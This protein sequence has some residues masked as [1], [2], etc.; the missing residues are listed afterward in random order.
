[1]MRQTHKRRRV[2][3]SFATKDALPLLSPVVGDRICYE[4]WAGD[5]LHEEQALRRMQE[6]GSVY[7][8]TWEEKRHERTGDGR[9]DRGAGGYRLHL[10]DGLGLHEGGRLP[11]ARTG[12]RVRIPAP[13][14]VPAMVP[15]RNGGTD[16]AEPSGR[17]AV[18]RRDRVED[19]ASRD[20]GR[21]RGGLDQ[22]PSRS[23]RSVHL[24]RGAGRGSEATVCALLLIVALLVSVTAIQCDALRR[25]RRRADDVLGC[26][27]DHGAGMAHPGDRDRLEG[28]KI[29][30]G[31]G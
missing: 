1:M 20:R 5:P 25:R 30:K 11:V 15:A 24:R 6:G 7:Y 18:R 19:R 31:A 13:V 23:A 8:T 16:D 3:L 26:S 21:E 17:P 4:T 27:V 22:W 29:L 9:G 14:S 12:E 2:P 10:C 28:F